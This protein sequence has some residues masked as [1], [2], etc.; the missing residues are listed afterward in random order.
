[1]A[2]TCNHRFVNNHP[3]LP[4]DSS[5]R[6][7]KTT[8]FSEQKTFLQPT[9]VFAS[10]VQDYSDDYESSY[11]FSYDFVEG[12]SA[13]AVVVFRLS[14]VLEVLLAGNESWRATPFPMMRDM[15]LLDCAF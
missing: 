15:T 9:V 2:L 10:E 6:D 3:A 8:V 4:Y 5:F 14:S 13:S 11:S 1:M 12:V 7:G